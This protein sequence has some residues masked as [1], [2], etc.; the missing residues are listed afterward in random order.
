MNKAYFAAA[1]LLLMSSMV[2][3]GASGQHHES[4]TKPTTP[5]TPSTPTSLFSV[6]AHTAYS[7]TASIGLNV[8]F[9][10]W[11]TPYSAYQ[12]E[13]LA[14][15]STLGIKHLRDQMDWQGSSAAEPFYEVHNQIGGM[16][17]KTDY[18]LEAIDTP[19]SE[20]TAYPTLVNDMEAIEAANEYDNSGVTGWASAIVAQQERLASTV[21]GSSEFANVTLL[22]PSMAFPAADNADLG[23]LSSYAQVS[24]LHAYFGACNPEN[25]GKSGCNNAAYF[26]SASQEDMPGMPIWAT[27]TGYW[28][29][30]DAFYGGYGVNPTVQGYYTPRELF[31]YYMAG[32]ARTYIYELMD[33][34]PGE[35]SYYG[36]ISNQD[37]PKPSYYA[38]Q[39]LLS[40]LADTGSTA[41]TFTP[42]SLNFSAT[43]GTDVA[44][45]LFEKSNG[46]FYL[47]LWV[48]EP[49]MNPSN[50]ESITVP[51]QSVTVNLATTPSA[52]TNYAWQTAGTVS[53]STV[54]PS[55][56]IPVTV[57]PAITILQLTM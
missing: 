34:E 55:T 7:F 51:T 17:I 32:F 1:S 28:S 38:L 48:A 9:S 27:E 26:T 39:G 18:I 50:G 10:Y 54:K 47:A 24:N 6:Q 40:T 16:G 4:P 25:P 14:D 11:G 3:L 49:S 33:D 31:A 46:T 15:L 42:A 20:V 23:K 45:L 53:S 35:H 2:T 43:G 37:I 44:S 52:V 21:H 36:L 30:Q 57:G 12:K 22:S 13:L 8:H 41:A 56:A 29:D 5:A 19:M